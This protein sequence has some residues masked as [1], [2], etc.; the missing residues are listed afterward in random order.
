MRPNI[1]KKFL[2]QA[3]TEERSD[4]TA[5]TQGDDTA[6]EKPYPILLELTSICAGL[7]LVETK[8]K[9]VD[10]Q[11]K[12]AEEKDPAKQ[13]SLTIIHWQALIHLHK[14]LLHE[15]YDFFLTLQH[16]SASPALSRLASKYFM[17]ARMWRYG[18]YA[19]LEVLR[20]RLPASLEYMLDFF[21]IAYSMMA[22]LYDTV[23][24]FEDT[25]ME[26]L[27][28]IGHY[29]MAIEKD[30]Q[31]R[32]KWAGV[33]R[34]WYS[35][36]VDANPGTGRL[37]HHLAILAHPYTLQQLSFYFR[38]R[39]SVSP[40]E[41]TTDSIMTLFNPIMNGKYIR[42]T[43]AETTFIKAHGILF[44]EGANNQFGDAKDEWISQL[45]NYI[46]CVT[47]IF[48]KHGVLIQV[49]NI[50]AIFEYGSTSSIVRRAYEES[51]REMNASNTS[52]D[53]K[54]SI[55][56]IGSPK[57]QPSSQSSE[58]TI[59]YASSLTFDTLSVCLQRVGDKN[60]L[61]LVHVTFAFILSLMDVD[62]AMKAVQK[63]IPWEKICTFLNHLAK[64]ESMTARV[65]ADS[66]PRPEDSGRPLPEDFIMRGEVFAQRFF[67]DSFFCDAKVDFEERTIELPSMEDA[68]D[69]RILW[70]GL[71][72]ASVCS[73]HYRVQLF[74]AYCV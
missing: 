42:P 37:Y 11:L 12:A 4:P 55:G 70:L 50:S 60:V 39:T 46:G 74:H 32:D 34:G 19:F 53:T 20:H 40:F 38:S 26:F 71:R 21:D 63:Q 62:K 67:P 68:R 23:S 41:T 35:K 1:G 51:Q 48:K 28:D 15:H 59:L 31:D 56:S 5:T 29:R 72:M 7:F 47:S 73:L 66:F 30:Q 13:T 44:S 22:L 17:P 58:T 61:P 8:C 18:I 3:Y 10:E 14:T 2:G 36:A 6:Q 16:P 64:P 33:A 43:S 25:W 49:V 27:G 54:S 9:H 45:G 69:E 65:S 52:K 57:Q 24:T